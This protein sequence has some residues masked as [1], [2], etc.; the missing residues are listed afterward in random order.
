MASRKGPPFFNEDNVGPVHYKP[1]FYE[2]MKLFIETLTGM[3][4]ELWVSPL[5]TVGSVKA[6]IQIWEGIPVSQQHL[7]WNNLVLE[8]ECCLKSYGISE[9]C[10]LKLILA[11]RGGPI[12]TRRVPVEDPIREIT[13]YMDHSRDD[14]WEKGPSNKQTAF[15]ILREG[16]QVNFVLVLDKGDGTVTPLSES[17]SGGSIYKLYSDDDED[18]EASP[19]GQQIIE[20]SITMNKMKLLK[21]KME[22]MNLSKK[23]K[24]II[25]VFPHPP[26]TPRPSS[27]SIAAAHHRFFQALPQ[28]GQSGLLSPGNSFASEL[29]QKAFSALGTADGRVP[30]ITSE[31]FKGK[32]KWEVLSQPQSVGTTRVMSK[33]TCIEKEAAKLPRDNTVLVPAPLTSSE[34]NVENGAPAN[35]GAPVLCPNLRNTDLHAAEE[36]LTFIPNTDALASTEA[37]IAEPCSELYVEQVNSERVRMSVGNEDCNAAEHPHKLSTKLLTSGTADACVLNSHELNSQ[38]NAG[39]SPLQCSVQTAR[40]SPR[41]PHAPFKCFESGNFRPAAPPNVLRSLEVRNLADSSY[42]RSPRHHGIRTDSPGKRPDT[43]SKIEARGIT[44]VA[45]KASK[46]P[47]ISVNNVGLLTSLARNTNRDDLQNSSGTSRFRTSGITLTT[48]FQHF[49]DESFRVTSP[50][51]DMPGYFLSPGLGYGNIMATGKRIGDTTHLP[52]VNGSVKTKK[53]I[54]K[55]CC[56]CGKKT[57]LATSYEYAETTSVRLTVMQRLTPVLTTTRMQDAGTCRSQILW[58][59]LQNFPKSKLGCVACIWL[60][61]GEKWRLELFFFGCA[62]NLR[63]AK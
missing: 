21:A 20:N 22:N 57:G 49:Q 3:C 11:M 30:A 62:S 39:L 41:K 40:C 43:R 51:N 17:L 5:E 31:F 53:K 29:P 61:Y 1:P 56:F 13:E 35:E 37:N 14:I 47:V 59:V 48:N 18:G 2:T 19:S 45:I 6:K 4:F 52:P 44:E 7:I 34:N 16:E 23:P 42:A 24:K 15:L 55:H 54:A 8:D 33:T 63:F 10:T 26:M 9:G 25:K 28:I 58:S 46:E 60:W 50:H 27:G 32:D 38:K 12:N 36:K